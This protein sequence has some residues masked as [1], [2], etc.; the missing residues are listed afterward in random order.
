MSIF[1]KHFHSHFLIQIF[2]SKF[3]NTML[4]YS[5]LS[6]FLIILMIGLIESIDVCN[7]LMGLLLIFSLFQ[8]KAYKS[9]NEFV[10]SYKKPIVTQLPS[11]HTQSLPFKKTMSFNWYDVLKI[12]GSFLGSLLSGTSC[13]CIFKCIRNKC[14]CK[15][16]FHVFNDRFYNKENTCRLH[17][18]S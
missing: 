15:V 3:I 6:I 16:Q 7:I 2:L 12:L 17:G 14:Q 18:G 8:L 11:Y 5:F 13:Y 1:Y 9:Y 4:S 10:S